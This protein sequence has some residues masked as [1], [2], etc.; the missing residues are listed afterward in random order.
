MA[1][2]TALTMEASFYS[3]CAT[4][5]IR[6]VPDNRKIQ[7]QYASSPESES[8]DDLI[9]FLDCGTVE[10][11]SRIQEHW[12]PCDISMFK[13]DNSDFASLP[14]NFG[15]PLVLRFYVE[16][17]NVF[18]QVG[19]YQNVL[20]DEMVNCFDCQKNFSKFVYP[21]IIMENCCEENVRKYDMAL[22]S[23]YN[24]IRFKKRETL[25]KC[26]LIMNTYEFASVLA[27]T[28][29]S[30]S[31]SFVE[32]N[33]GKPRDLEQNIRVTPDLNETDEA[34]GINDLLYFWFRA[35]AR[36]LR[37]L[38]IYEYVTVTGE[39]A[40]IIT[41]CV[42]ISH[43]TFSKIQI[44]NGRNI[45]IFPNISS[46]EFDGQCLGVIDDEIRFVKSL[47]MIFPNVKVVCFKGT[48]YD[49]LINAFLRSRNTL[50]SGDTIKLYQPVTDL[51][52]VQHQMSLIYPKTE[53]NTFQ[54]G[55]Y[56]KTLT[57]YNE[58]YN[59]KIILY[60]AGEKF[61]NTL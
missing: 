28:L 40:K 24:A 20:P 16:E 46:F 23:F 59:T 50:E 31:H 9:H 38:R 11:I 15:A 17:D 3:D 22:N 30:L 41:G 45:C 61:K 6:S 60:R 29:S 10:T 27:N 14:I 2:R 58:E 13:S 1:K 4:D 42:S 55:D 21:Y 52:K 8:S 12:K 35:N 48:S 32:I 36:S 26:V 34:S 37:C 53:L 33:I 25:L 19:I 18:T 5:S 54:A 47:K 39:F 49:P 7:K 57:I 43:L 44:V 51:K 56:P